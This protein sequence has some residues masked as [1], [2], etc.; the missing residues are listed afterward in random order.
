MSPDTEH[1]G[2]R[3]SLRALDGDE[4]CVVVIVDADGTV[5]HVSTNFESL[6]GYSRY[7]IL[8]MNVRDLSTGRRD[9]AFFAAFRDA[10]RTGR[11]WSG[12]LFSSRAD[13]SRRTESA[14]ICP[15]MDESGVVNRC[16]GVRRD[17]TGPR[18]LEEALR[19]SRAME[20]VA[21]LAGGMAHNF[22]N[23]LTPIIGYSD[24]LLPRLA[25]DAAAMRSVEKIR[26]AGE[27]AATLT[28]MLVAFSREQA[29]MPTALD[30]NTLVD[31]VGRQLRA[32]WSGG[33]DI[34]VDCAE[35][36]GTVMADPAQIEYAVVTLAVNAGDAMPRGGQLTFATENVRFDAPLVCEGVHVPP[37]DYVMLAVSDTGTAM[38]DDTRNTLFEPFHSNEMDAS[39]LELAAVYGIV[40]QSGG[41]IRAFSR[42]ELGT[43]FELYL[44]RADRATDA[45]G[46]GRDRA[47]PHPGA[48]RLP[49]GRRQVRRIE[50]RD[51]PEVRIAAPEGP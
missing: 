11:A 34:R 23:L 4:R 43:T 27:R 42:P 28:R 5:R 12:T 51:T 49:G 13:G 39:G 35:D 36:L 38:D 6:C 37:G 40:R 47:V 48:N 15:V 50:L 45:A 41:H 1:G 33:I 32:R 29:L 20:A 31:L 10:L 30:L 44:P 25:G 26:E 9:A 24:L 3:C 22:N 17:L 18:L 2:G 21:R 19:K 7:E 8:G 16:A 46:A 14:T